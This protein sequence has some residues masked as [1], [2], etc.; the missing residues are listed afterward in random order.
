MSF[1]IWLFIACVISE[2][3]CWN[4]EHCDM[5]LFGE[6]SMVLF[7]WGELRKIMKMKYIYIREEFQNTLNKQLTHD[8]ELILQNHPWGQGRAQRL[9][10]S[11]LKVC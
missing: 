8:Q 3:Y 1:S 6:L 2:R 7:L 9:L 4:C 5:N 10:C 11:V